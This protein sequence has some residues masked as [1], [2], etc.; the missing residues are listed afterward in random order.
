MMVGKS[1]SGS[2]SWLLVAARRWF[3]AE[4]AM[5]IFMQ[6]D[7]SRENTYHVHERSPSSSV[8]GKPSALK[9]AC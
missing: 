5:T 1:P 3:S 6:D 9:G 7:L 8:A 4:P 2:R